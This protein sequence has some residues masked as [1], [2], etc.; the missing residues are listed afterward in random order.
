M[1]LFIIPTNAQYAVHLVGIINE[2]ID[3]KGTEWTNLFSWH[4]PK[5]EKQPSHPPPPKKRSS[6]S[7]HG[8]QHGAQS[9]TVDLLD[10]KHKWYPLNHNIW[11]YDNKQ[12][13]PP[14][15]DTFIISTHAHKMKYLLYLEDVA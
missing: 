2:Y 4:L 15:D 5:T 7:S 3:Q 11:L 12:T 6:S 8:S 10:T 14:C 13:Y 1:Y 9:W